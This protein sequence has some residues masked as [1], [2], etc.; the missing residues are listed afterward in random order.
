MGCPP[1]TFDLQSLIIAQRLGRRLC[2][3]CKQ[4][5][6]VPKE[7]L[8]EEGFTE[9]QVNTGLPFMAPKAVKSAGGLLRGE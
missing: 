8:L 9:A 1:S 6:K 5:K 2:S 7:V 4:E 3:V